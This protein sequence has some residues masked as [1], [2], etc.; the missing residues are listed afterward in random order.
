MRTSIMASTIIICFTF[1]L[2][3][4]MTVNS[5]YAKKVEQQT[6][7]NNVVDASLKSIE[8]DKEYNSL[9]Y[10]DVVGDMVALIVAQSDTEG[11]VSVTI[12]E[13]NTKEGLLDIEVTK[14]YKWMGAVR[15]I[16]TRRTVILEEFENPPSIEML[17]KFV[18]ED[19]G[20]QMCIQR[21][22]E[23]FAGAI[24]KRPKN[25]KVKNKT[26]VGWSLTDG[27]AKISDEEWQNYIVPEPASETD[28]EIT[29][30]AIFN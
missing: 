19:E 9:N 1:V 30:Y 10:E 2:L 13:A 5:A 25:P 21:E 17:V 15:Q 22:D 23:T 8:L 14:T 12:L 26:F 6:T 18:Y 7:L 3:T 4:I 24:L 16:T 28:T 27:G 29:F 11:D 20:G